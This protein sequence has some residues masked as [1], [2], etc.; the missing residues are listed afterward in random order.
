[1]V[2]KLNVLCTEV[3]DVLLNVIMGRGSDLMEIG[4][5]SIGTCSLEIGGGI[6]QVHCLTSFR[7]KRP[8][9]RAQSL[10]HC[11]VIRLYR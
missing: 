8:K 7:F 9:Y 5:E 10:L 3:I 6:V 1:M 4:K 2:T 11:T